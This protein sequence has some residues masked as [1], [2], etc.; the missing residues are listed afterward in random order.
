MSKPVAPEP[1]ESSPSDVEWDPSQDNAS[2]FPAVPSFSVDT[3]FFG[4]VPA[5]SSGDFDSHLFGDFVEPNFEFADELSGDRS[6]WLGENADRADGVETFADGSQMCTTNGQ[7]DT[8]NSTVFQPSVSAEVHHAIFSHNLLSNCETSSITLP[9][10]TEFYKDLF[11]EGTPFENL[12]PRVPL[13]GLVDVN[14]ATDPQKV[15][16]SLADV[17]DTTACHPVFASHVSCVDD[18]NFL[19]RRET[20]RLAAV[21]KLLVVIRHCL[22]ASSTGR[23]IMGLGVDASQSPEA[24]DIVSAVVGIKSPATLVKRANALLSFLRWVDKEIRQVDNAF[25]EATVWRYMCH[26]KDSQAP[27]TRGASL[28]SALRFARFVLGFDGLDTVVNSR[29]LLGLS[30]IMVESKRL[31]RQALVLTVTQVLGLHK[32]LRSDSLHCM[33]KAVVAYLLIALY[34][35]CRHSDLQ[36]ISSLECDYNHDGGFMLI[37]TCCHKTG[38]M[39]ALK[40][41]LLPIMIPARGVDGSLWAEDAMK[42]LFEAGVDLTAPING[43]LLK[44]PAGGIGNFMARGLKSSEVSALLRH[45]VGAADPMP[46]Q[47]APSVS[48]HSLK[49]T[50]LS[51]CARY[52]LS[53]STRSLLGRHVSSLHETFAIYSRDL[54]CAPVAELQGVIDDIHAG[55]FSP[56]CQRSEFFK[57]KPPIVAVSEPTPPVQSASHSTLG[58][59][60]PVGVDGQPGDT[61]SQPEEPQNADETE[62]VGASSDSSSLSDSQSS[63]DSSEDAPLP[64]VKRFRP[65]IPA[66]EAWFVHAR[67]HLVH[68]L[69]AN[70]QAGGDLKFLACGKRL[71][72]AYHKC[73]EADAWNTLCQSCN[74]R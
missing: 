23:H 10:E 24:V 69:D 38:R 34:G 48:S 15:A 28:M 35:R 55:K 36:F 70:D 16:E 65:R 52:G 42:A 41:R 29:R 39:A 17:A 61:Q 26:L 51:W 47:A 67:S 54:A 25:D 72:A 64:K 59:W 21:W 12:V 3:G 56:D 31:L 5:Q 27:A 30:D 18:A 14:L 57:E 6:Q 74:K 45:F 11:D 62:S 66:D 4:E 40:S 73:T 22:P 2:I 44:A 13:G 9:W 37:Q 1:V 53:P 32:A 49:S 50:A 68:R 60:S 20:L 71:T 43:P 33:D 63:Q 46:G 19:E 58:S 8:C 7:L